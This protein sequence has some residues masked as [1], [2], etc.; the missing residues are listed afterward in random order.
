[1]YSGILTPDSLYFLK[2]FPCF[3]P[4]RMRHR[5]K[6]FG[7]SMI[8]MPDFDALPMHAHLKRRKQIHI[9]FRSAESIHNIK[10][11]IDPCNFARFSAVSQS[12]DYGAALSFIFGWC[13]LPPGD[14]GVIGLDA[15]EWIQIQILNRITRESRSSDCLIQIHIWGALLRMINKLLDVI[16]FQ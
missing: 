9:V 5:L 8:W 1:M 14:R 10:R 4:L 16:N 6:C 7:A 2:L 13:C 3:C 11:G 12:C 15:V